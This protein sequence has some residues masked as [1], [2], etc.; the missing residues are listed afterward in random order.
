MV[1]PVW[2]RCH[3]CFS[4]RVSPV[5]IPSVIVARRTPSHTPATTGAGGRGAAALT[6]GFCPA[7]HPRAANVRATMET[8]ANR[9]RVP[10]AQKSRQSTNYQ[11]NL[12]VR[13]YEQILA[14]QSGRI[15]TLHPVLA[16]SVLPEPHQDQSVAVRTP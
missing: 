2:V 16:R 12:P 9:I 14:K 3:S 10:P 6:A 7:A 4:M 11:A 15:E 13:N 8:P 5:P 1:A